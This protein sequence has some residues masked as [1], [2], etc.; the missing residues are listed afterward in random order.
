MKEKV[1]RTGILLSGLTV[2][3][4]AF[5]AHS[6]NSLLTE[7]GRTETYKTAVFYQFFHSIAIII[8][9][10]MYERYDTKKLN[11]SFYL[12]IAGIVLFSGS[13]YTLSI[14]NITIFGAIT[15]IGGIMFILGWLNLYLATKKSK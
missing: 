9:A 11:T 10:F 2:L 15:P 5:G 12:F 6:L 7:Y 3:I 4:G 14:T 13:L 1:F 8:T